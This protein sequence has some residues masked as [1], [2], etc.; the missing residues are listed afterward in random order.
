VIISN[1]I[2][3]N[4]EFF[5]VIAEPLL[6]EAIVILRYHFLDGEVALSVDDVVAGGSPG[7]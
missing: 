1:L 7:L 6:E 4:S 2:G 5:V 3:P